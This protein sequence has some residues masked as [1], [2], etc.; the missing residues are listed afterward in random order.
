MTTKVPPSSI[1]IQSAYTLVELLIVMALSLALLGSS[2]KVLVDLRFDAILDRASE[3]TMD[4]L[5]A[6]L[7]YRSTVHVVPPDRPD[8]ASMLVAPNQ[9]SDA[10]TGEDCRT[11]TGFYTYGVSAIGSSSVN[12]CLKSGAAIFVGTSSADFS[13]FEEEVRNKLESILKDAG[14][15]RFI[16]LVLFYPPYGSIAM[17]PSIKDVWLAKLQKAFYQKVIENKQFTGMYPPP[18]LPDGSPRIGTGI[19]YNLTFTR[20]DGKYDNV[21]WNPLLD[22]IAPNLPSSLT[23]A[24][25]TAKSENAGFQFFFVDQRYG[26]N[27]SR[28]L[29]PSD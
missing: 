8:L 22:G 15:H 28:Y 17:H 16:K 10:S 18:A 20:S 2:F 26:H 21:L 5:I 23:D 3:Q 1:R 19:E 29:E 4:V 9:P 11:G 14:L 24:W 6:A 13:S 7:N 27:T 25:Y 12:Q